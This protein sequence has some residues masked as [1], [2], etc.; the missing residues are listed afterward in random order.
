MANVINNFAGKDQTILI[1]EE[2]TFNTPVAATKDIGLVQTNDVRETNNGKRLYAI[3]SPLLQD[4]SLG[5]YDATVDWD[6]IWQHGRMLSFVFGNTAHAALGGGDHQHT[7][8]VVGTPGSFT[9]EVG[10]EGNTDITRTYSGCKVNTCG[11]TGALNEPLHMS[12]SVL[13]ADVI[14]T[15]AT[16][17]E[18][19]D[20][21]P[22]LKYT[23]GSLTCDDGTGAVSALQVQR[24]ALTFNANAEKLY[25]IG[26]RGAQGAHNRNFEVDFS[27]DC[28]WTA[29]SVAGT[30]YTAQDW[31]HT[32]LGDR[33]APAYTPGNAFLETDLVLAYD[34][35]IAPGADQ[36]NVTVNLTDSVIN[37]MSTP[38]T[39]DGVIYATF[40]GWCK[41]PS[42]VSVD[43]IPQAD[44]L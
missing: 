24:F 44:W 15:N 35:G 19:I 21:L 2:V 31:Y 43:D 1:G 3:G 8:T 33:T 38:V 29:E 26:S 30:S 6:I 18:A 17:G 5:A 42:V 13:A 4:W 36:R 7:F 16:T 11:L 37:D 39:Q 40:N 20:L 25:G 10:D 28:A 41:T 22:A 12:N 34:N 14:Q 9:L 23:E 27:V 32:F